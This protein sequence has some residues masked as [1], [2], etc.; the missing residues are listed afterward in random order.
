MNNT[1][2]W[3]NNFEM[4]VKMKRFQAATYTLVVTR[5]VLIAITRT[6]NCQ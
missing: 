6:E 2:Q 5:E 1:K 4:Y 3:K